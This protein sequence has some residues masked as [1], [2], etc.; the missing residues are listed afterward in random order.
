MDARGKRLQ[1]LRMPGVVAGFSDED[2]GGLAGNPPGW[3]GAGRGAVICC[4]FGRRGSA[5]VGVR[6][7]RRREGA[8][9]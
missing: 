7:G 5:V 8:G 2:G 4:G 1:R 9:T 6:E 3:V